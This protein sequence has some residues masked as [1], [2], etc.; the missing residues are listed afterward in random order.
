M[1]V[2][3]LFLQTFAIPGS[4]FLS[5]VSGFLFSFP[6]ALLLVRK[7]K[8]LLSYSSYLSLDDPP[9]VLLLS[10]WCLVL[11]PA[12]LSGGP[13]PGAEVPAGESRQLVPKGGSAQGRHAQLYH[14]SAVSAALK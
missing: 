12:E 6:V 13:T 1:F 3:Y 14:F 7:L 2:T 11:L 10:H 4:I 9:G 8:S 5:I